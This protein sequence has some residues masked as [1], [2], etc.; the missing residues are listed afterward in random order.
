MF[1]NLCSARKGT[2]NKGSGCAPAPLIFGLLLFKCVSLDIREGFLEK[3]NNR[4]LAIAQ[5]DS[6]GE[7]R[8]TVACVE[9]G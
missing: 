1:M 9:F 5:T 3:S 4:R 8:L 7:R 2:E 6:R